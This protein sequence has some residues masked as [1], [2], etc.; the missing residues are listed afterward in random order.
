M[1]IRTGATARR[2]MWR[3]IVC[4]KEI[5]MCSIN[6]ITGNL[7]CRYMN[8]TVINIANRY[9]KMALIDSLLALDPLPAPPINIH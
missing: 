6:E 1:I 7:T 2:H 3:Q 9:K 5:T 8:K 4:D